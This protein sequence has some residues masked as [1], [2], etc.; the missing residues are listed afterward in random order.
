MTRD[1][2]RGKAPLAS[3]GA[4]QG[5]DF[6]ARRADGGVQ[7]DGRLQPGR[8][9]NDRGEAK[10]EGVG[11]RHRVPGGVGGRVPQAQPIHPRGSLDRYVEIRILAGPASRAASEDA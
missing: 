3:Q 11:L 10:A 2:A 5:L 4:A 6:G 7:A 8:R 9:E 1:C